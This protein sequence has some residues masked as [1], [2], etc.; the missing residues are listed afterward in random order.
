MMP[1][2]F[3]DA[4]FGSLLL[5]RIMFLLFAY[6]SS[7]HMPPM[8]YTS[9]GADFCK[10]LNQVIREMSV[11]GIRLNLDFWPEKKEINWNSGWY[12]NQDDRDDSS[13]FS[14]L[15]PSTGMS[16]RDEKK[17]MSATKVGWHRDENRDEARWLLR[18]DVRGHVITGM[19][20]GMSA[21]DHHDEDRDDRDEDCRQY[22]ECA[23]EYPQQTFPGRLGE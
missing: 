20:T 7:P 13:W 1:A 2:V 11:I 6:I 23:A 4:C 8:D 9:F 10:I 15:H 14:N 5:T 3:A 12:T 19:K 22:G 16:D 17:K 18:G 21:L